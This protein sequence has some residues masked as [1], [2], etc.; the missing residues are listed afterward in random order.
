MLYWVALRERQLYIKWW[1]T[2][3]VNSRVTRHVTAHLYK[4]VSG[5]FP[6][7]HVHYSLKT[8]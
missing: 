3:G 6:E 1:P 8:S 2:L 4:L 7:L 5:A